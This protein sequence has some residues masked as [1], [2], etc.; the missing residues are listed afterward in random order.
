MLPK[1]APR[2]LYH[3][4]DDVLFALGMFIYSLEPAEN[5]MKNQ[6]NPRFVARGKAIFE[7]ENCVRCHK[8]PDYSGDKVMPVHGYS[9]PR[10]HPFQN[11]IRRARIDT[12]SGLALKTRKGTG[13]YKIPSLR[14]LWYRGLFSHDGS[15]NS[16]EDWFDPK[17]LEDNYVPTGWKGPGVERRAVPGHEYGLD[18]S[19]E[20]KK[21]LISFLKT[22]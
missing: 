22:L 15:V 21:A 11:R 7:E 18:L 17:R 3:V 20:D 19:E 13:F 2:P 16:L 4:E 14:G 5:P 9:V 8:A 1:E 6:L 10:N 12:D